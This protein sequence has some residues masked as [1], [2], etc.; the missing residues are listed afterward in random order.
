MCSKTASC[1]KM[2]SRDG[3]L[4][5][6]SLILPLIGHCDVSSVGDF[7]TFYTAV[8]R[9]WFTHASYSD[10]LLVEIIVCLGILD[11]ATFLFFTSLLLE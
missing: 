7:L 10:S 1:A 6:V 2:Y 4:F 8:E 3:L 11:F 9:F 5:S